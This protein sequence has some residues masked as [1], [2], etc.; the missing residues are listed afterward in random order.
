MELER[1]SPLP[2]YTTSGSYSSDRHGE[3]VRWALRADRLLPVRYGNGS[4]C[5]ESGSVLKSFRR[6]RWEGMIHRA[7]VKCEDGLRPSRPQRLICSRRR[8]Y[9]P[10]TV[11]LWVNALPGKVLKTNG[12]QKPRA[13]K[14]E[15][16]VCVKC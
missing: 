9:I 3:L 5:N 10:A 7:T 1:A 15:H 4:T 13:A 6:A 16:A 14:G 12:I 8:A 11:L 2:E